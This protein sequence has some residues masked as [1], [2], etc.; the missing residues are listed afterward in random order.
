MSPTQAREV[1]E[2]AGERIADWK[3]R[4]RINT[5]RGVE[6]WDNQGNQLVSVSTSSEEVVKERQ[7][8]TV[9]LWAT[10]RRVRFLD[11]IDIPPKDGA[12]PRPGFRLSEGGVFVDFKDR[13]EFM[14]LD[15]LE[16]GQYSN[17]ETYKNSDKLEPA[18]PDYFPAGYFRAVYE[19]T[20]FYGYEAL[21]RPVSV[22]IGPEGYE[23][24]NHTVSTVTIELSIRAYTPAYIN[25]RNN[26]GLD[27]EFSKGQ[28]VGY[29][30]MMIRQ[31]DSD[32]GPT[33]S[34]GAYSDFNG[35]RYSTNPVLTSTRQRIGFAPVT[36]TFTSRSN[37]YNVASPGW[38]SVG[39]IEIMGYRKV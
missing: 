22:Q 27:I 35:G 34:I 33:G 31:S 12:E 15:S 1:I 6:T 8:F 9:I 37:G 5:G 23:F 10:L 21:Y 4:L 36:M 38:E 26:R 39:Q 17:E 13:H 29:Y 24:Q 32:K 2:A 7:N 19:G 18:D 30:D 3:S 16:S 11:P 20:P 25:D 14:T 28:S